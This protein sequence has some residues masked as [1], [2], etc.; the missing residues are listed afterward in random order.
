MWFADVHADYHSPPCIYSCL[1]MPIGLHPAQVLGDLFEKRAVDTAAFAA[2]TG[3]LV[4][5]LTDKSSQCRT[6]AMIGLESALARNPYGARLALNWFQDTLKTERGKLEACEQ[7]HA[8]M[9]AMA[10]ASGVAQCSAFTVCAM[11]SAMAGTSARCLDCEGWHQSDQ[12]SHADLLSAAATCPGCVC[13]HPD[14]IVVC[15]DS[16]SA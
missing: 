11:S 2:T 1:Q 6:A 4:A 10:G 5:A 13:W 15:H 3:A 14:I 12:D 8:A 7:H 9:A 16:E